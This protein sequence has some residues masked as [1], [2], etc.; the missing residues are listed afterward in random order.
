MSDEWCPEN[1]GAYRAELAE[2]YRH[3]DQR[4]DDLHTAAM[5]R[6]YIAGLEA[7]AVRL[8]KTENIIGSIL[9]KL[10]DALAPPEGHISMHAQ[11]QTPD[12]FV[13]AAYESC[14]LIANIR[15]LKDPA[16]VR[17]AVRRAILA[18][19]DTASATQP[20]PTGGPRDE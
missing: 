13:E 19:L 18:L 5:E 9:S 6:A 16:H 7:A 11:G 20:A 10:D 1:D 8:Q 15:A 12:W 4:R 17:A 14:Y 3:L 2:K